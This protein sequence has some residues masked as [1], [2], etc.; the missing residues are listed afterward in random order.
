MAE[1]VTG[2]DR[3]LLLVGLTAFGEASD[4]G[5]DGIRAQVHS[6]VNRQRAGRWYSRK[7]L[8][9]CVML[10]YAYSVW[11][12]NDKNAARICEADMS[13]P[14]MVMC[15]EEAAAAIAGTTQ[16]PTGGATHYY[17]AGT[18]EPSWVTGRNAK[19]EQVAPPATYT[20]RVGAHLFYKDVT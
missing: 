4:Q 6:V 7:T 18:K 10:G 12:D 19:G 16:D 11:N 14:V 17:V 9:A 2:A 15:M 3:D 13:D 20:V 8:A 5:R 1:A